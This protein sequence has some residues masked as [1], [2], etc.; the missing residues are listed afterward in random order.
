[1]DYLSKD[2]IIFL[3]S[4]KIEFERALLNSFLETSFITEAKESGNK[5][6]KAFSNLVTK[7]KTF[8]RTTLDKIKAKIFGKGSSSNGVQ[9]ITID[10]ALRQLDD[11]LYEAKS[12]GLKSVKMVDINT[13]YELLNSFTNDM[14]KEI[15]KFFKKYKMAGNPKDAENFM[16]TYNREYDKFS[17][18]YNKAMKTEREYSI[19]DAMSISS[20]LKAHTDDITKS[21]DECNM[22]LD[23]L[24]REYNAIAASVYDLENRGKYI[25][26]ANKFS[27]VLQNHI[28]HIGRHVLEYG[29]L[30]YSTV[31]GTLRFL[32]NHLPDVVV[33]TKLLDYTDGEPA[34][35]LKKHIA[36][37]KKYKKDLTDYAAIAGVATAHVNRRS[38]VKDFRKELE[39]GPAPLEQ[40]ENGNYKA[41]KSPRL[42][43]R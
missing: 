9:Q 24:N 40:D 10:M 20:K 32:A 22:M 42:K 39:R 7:L 2:D 43:F 14:N 8:I 33:N 6:V 31:R 15:D 35:R 29:A 12:K 26:G 28:H 30:T 27:E 37:G 18:A 19:G 25:V 5:L 13:A 21:L 11:K 3:S 4:Y 34:K 36:S 38:E 16:N 17:D 41:Q 23:K 1:M